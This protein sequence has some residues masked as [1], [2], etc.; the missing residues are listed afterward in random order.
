MKCFDIILTTSTTSM[1]IKSYK[2]DQCSMSI[3]F[4]DANKEFKYSRHFPK[5]DDDMLYAP[6][7][8]PVLIIPY[9]QS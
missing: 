2:P 7:A 6:I 1:I 9:V 3:F 8:Y 4:H 5:T